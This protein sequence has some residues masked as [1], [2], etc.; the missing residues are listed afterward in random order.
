MFETIK[1]VFPK[2][3]QCSI[4][5]NVLLQWLFD[6]LSNVLLNP[7]FA[8]LRGEDTPFRF[9]Q[10]FTSTMKKLS[11]CAPKPGETILIRDMAYR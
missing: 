3:V 1:L 8:V 6:K 7:K 10:Y 11:T 4:N 9:C 2:G 5:E